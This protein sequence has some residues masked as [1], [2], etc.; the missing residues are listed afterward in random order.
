MSITKQQTIGK[1]KDSGS[2][3]FLRDSFSA[4]ATTQFLKK[5]DSNKFIS[6]LSE[7]KQEFMP[8]FDVLP[9]A[10][11][12]YDEAGKVFFWSK[13]NETIYG[14]SGKEALGNSIAD[15]IIPKNLK[16]LFYNCLER[17]KKMEQS[18]LILPTGEIEL[19]NKSGQPV[20][21]YTM[22]MV[23]CFSSGER[24][25]F[26]I[27]I[28]LSERKELENQL[29]DVYEKM[30][31]KI[32]ERTWQFE[33][34][35]QSLIE[36]I[37]R[38]RETENQLEYEKDK[39]TQIFENINCGCGI[40]EAADNGNDFIIKKLNKYSLTLEKR[41]KHDV[42][43]KSLKL[44]FPG[45]EEMGLWAVFKDVWKTGKSRWLK[46]AKYKDEKVSGWRENYVFKLTSGEIVS[47][48][49][50][51][52]P[53]KI[54]SSISGNS[55]S[56][57]KALFDNSFSAMLL[58]DPITGDIIDANQASTDFYGLSRKNLL[59]KNIRDIDVSDS[60]EV[61][62]W[63]NDICR[64]RSS[65]RLTKHV[66]NDGS[67]RNVEMYISRIKISMKEV[68]YSIIL[69]VTEKIRAEQQ[70]QRHQKKLKALASELL[71][72][73]EQ[74]RRKIS[75]D[76]HDRISQSL[77]MTKMKIEKLHEQLVQ[78]ERKELS[79]EILEEINKTI[80][81]TRDLTFD[82]NSPVLEEFGFEA[83]ISDW[84]IENVQRKNGI[85]CILESDNSITRFDKDIEIMLF[86]SVRELFLN[87]IKHAQAKMV[88]FSVRNIGE[89]IEIIVQ[90]DGKGFNYNA[91]HNRGNSR[92]LGLFSIKERLEYLQGRLEI[93]SE[94]NV[95]SKIKIV[96]PVKLKGAEHGS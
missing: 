12:G 28:D 4:F 29:Q 63:L 42:V 11:Q 5:I 62:S 60:V 46:S 86:R 21:V 45:V 89:S 17:G 3:G 35:N 43:D 91:V 84:M 26:S 9:C 94:N 49:R 81:D 19:V 18:G 64:K 56:I 13:A 87:V 59:E 51:I 2:V 22:N 77:V 66:L 83:A 16:T 8:L 38:C 95:G 31:E 48:Y 55:K 76:V 85:K 75:I 72:S 69:D 54:A 82:L 30:D 32:A 20:Y 27:D 96:L 92:A 15:L 7:F 50:D 78:P 79:Q 57:Y 6:S 47:I 74:E 52:T 37:E 23:V 58:I 88:K 70:L 40:F 25:F 65:K 90:D 1:I 61:S 71:L 68:I 53:E 67:V 93:G 80:Q 14:Y 44:V 73:E 10:F 33:V 24:L 39:F 34:A 41:K 36:Q